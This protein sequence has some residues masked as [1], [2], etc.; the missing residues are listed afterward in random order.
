M[1][2]N[3]ITGASD[4]AQAMAQES[5]RETLMGKQNTIEL[6][7]GGDDVEFE[8]ITV[9]HGSI[10][11]ETV[12]FKENARFQENLN[13]VSL[14]DI[15]PTIR[16]RGQQY[17]A[18]GRYMSNGMIEVLDG[19]RRRIACL[20]ASRDFLIYVTKEEIT[21]TDLAFLSDIANVHK[22]LSLFELGKKYNSLLKEGT[23]E[24]A[25]DLAKAESVT[26]SSV[27]AAISTIDMPSNIVELIPSISEIGRPSVNKLKKSITEAKRVGQIM[28]LEQFIKTL[29]IP[30]LKVK[31]GGDNT[32]STLNKLFI[33]SIVDFVTPEQQID[34]VTELK[35]PV[36]KFGK[37]KV[38]VKP[39]KRGYQVDLHGITDEK[40]AAVLA[41]IEAELKR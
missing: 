35:K 16:S 24:F 40:K 37:Q 8:L 17:P 27:S 28:A 19:S 22:P 26:E 4:S 29:N 6:P 33:D 15:L 30:A 1:R 23:Y 13:E 2:R 3:Q 9:P 11:T 38:F 36:F 14:S 10:R 39:T 32:P 31:S 18:I 20:L 21:T 25:K 41:A 5:A 12:V 34:I 7:I